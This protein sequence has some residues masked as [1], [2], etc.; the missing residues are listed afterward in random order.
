MPNG[1]AGASPKRADVP[2]AAESSREK[3]PGPETGR[4]R[5]WVCD[6]G[7]LVVAKPGN[8]ASRLESAHFSITDS[9][10]GTTGEIHRCRSCGFLLC[11]HMAEVLEYYQG[12]VDPA[13]EAGRPQRSLQ[14]RKLLEVVRR[15]K[16][17]GRLLDIGAG[18]GMLVEQALRMGFR[19]EGVEPSKWL[20]T[21]ATAHNL[22]VH[23]GT[24]PHPAAK[25]PYDVITLI[26]VIEHV[27]HP[28]QLLRSIRGSLSRD[29]LG[30]VVTPDVG[31]VAAR[32]LGDKWWHFRIAHIGYFNRETLTMA[33]RRAG[34]QPMG[35]LRPGW[36]FS[37]D[38]LLERISRYL[39]FALPLRITK[40]LRRITV[41]LNLR[42]SMLMIM[43]SDSN[44]RE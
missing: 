15:R 21:R 28:V 27:P 12:L 11:P 14:A 32:L 13:Y 37:A 29:G 26:D 31:S 35:M 44:P 34:L 17:S 19:A 18:S 22:P 6:S 30:V 3:T 16:L 9:H 39:P 1:S 38:Y 5:C 43:T 41:P 40:P 23:L 24:F 2:P 7:D 10:Y 36:Y 4:I 33:A 20:Q 8:L 25:G 42:D